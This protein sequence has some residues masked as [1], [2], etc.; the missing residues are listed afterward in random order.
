MEKNQDKCPKCGS[1]EY[2]PIVY[3]YPSYEAF[4]KSERGEIVLGGCCVGP[5]SKRHI[6]KKCNE[7]Y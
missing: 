6:C 3:G 5:D 4:E 7:N 1:K 2:I